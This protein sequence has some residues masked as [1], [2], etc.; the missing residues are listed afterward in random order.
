MLPFLDYIPPSNYKECLSKSFWWCPLI[1]ITNAGFTNS[2][3]T[4]LHDNGLIFVRDEWAQEDFTTN[5]EAQAKFNLTNT[6]VQNRERAI[7]MHR[8]QWGGL[9]TNPNGKI[10]CNEWLG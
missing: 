10:G 3:A 5:A 8:V 7:I 1:T 6:K 2:R 9:L 4:A